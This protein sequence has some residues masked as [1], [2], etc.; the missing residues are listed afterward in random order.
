MTSARENTPRA[1]GYAM[2][3]EWSLH[4][5]TWL[6]WPH[7]DGISF[8]GNY[9]KVLQVFAKIVD[10]LAESEEVR[11]NVL[12]NEEEKQV[13]SVLAGVRHDHVRF[14]HIPTNEPWCRDHGPMFLVSKKDSAL[15]A[16]DW[17]YNAWGYKYPPFDLDDAVPGRI[18]QAL[19]LKIYSPDMIL[20]GGS[21]DVNGEGVLMTTESC[22]LHPNRNP[23]MKRKDIERNLRDYVGVTQVIWLGDGIVGDDTDG[24]ID[25]IARFVRPYHVLL[26]QEDD[27]EDENFAALRDNRER[28]ENVRIHGK[29]LQIGYLPMPSQ[30]IRDGMRLPASYANFYIANKTVLMPAF[31]DPSDKLASAILQ[32]CFPDREVVAIDCRELIWGLGAFHCLTQQQPAVPTNGK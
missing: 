8:P 28:L 30:V 9:A 11:I 7:Q 2:P 18:A 15:A 1:D 21:I 13:L 23:E 12:D 4:E 6:S 5:A 20:E 29:S 19:G 10:A 22:L 14:F 17:G 3:A 16:V 25:D 31:C 32:K 26:A 27:S 24:H